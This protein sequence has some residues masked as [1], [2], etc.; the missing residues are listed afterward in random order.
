MSGAAVARSARRASL[1]LALST[2][3]RAGQHGGESKVCVQMENSDNMQYVIPIQI[4]NPGQKMMAIPDTGSFELVIPSTE[5]GSG[6]SGHPLF[7]SSVSTSFTYRGATQVIHYGQGDV[8][9]EVDYDTVTM[10]GMQ[11]TRQSLLQM[12]Y[13]G[14]ENYDLAIYDA[15]MGLG[16]SELARPNDA[17]L[18]LLASMSEKV[19][20]ICLG[21]HDNDPG[22]LDLGRGVPDLE[23]QYQELPC[24]K[25]T[26][27]WGL[28][29]SGFRVG[30]TDI[31]VGSNGMDMIVDS[32]TSLLALPTEVYEKVLSTIDPVEE[33][34]SNIDTL[35]DLEMS[36]GEYKFVIPPQLYVGK[37]KLDEAEHATTHLADRKWGPFRFRGS[38]KR[39]A[40][41]RVAMRLARKRNVS[42]LQDVKD[43]SYLGG[44][45]EG[46][47]LPL[48]MELNVFTDNGALFI[49][50]MP[51]LRAY[52]ARFDLAKQTIG[53]KKLPLG[54]NLCASCSS[55]DSTRGSGKVGISSLSGMG[56][57]KAG[58]R[59]PRGGAHQTI[60]PPIMSGMGQP[61]ARRVG[62]VGIN[63]KKLRLPWWAVRESVPRNSSHLHPSG[64]RMPNE[65]RHFQKRK[66]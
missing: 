12:T 27:H 33:D 15:V 31:T 2:T 48:F 16:L 45:A 57:P 26:G 28:Q 66:L 25:D 30:D 20:G 58:E 40:E 24:S 9:T 46:V 19:F 23:D 13:N 37:V 41:R 56:I 5:C 7:N 44:P 32:G 47:C 14:L 1:V 29:L 38:D 64:R 65:W 55:G 21:Q 53:L 17:D 61:M 39:K 51:F 11:V 36:V 6:C 63:L 62:P 3:A 4:G 60:L 42:L 52:S 22:R 50:G 59:K 10:A 18:S 35:P 8:T 34:C 54:S 43:E 49:L